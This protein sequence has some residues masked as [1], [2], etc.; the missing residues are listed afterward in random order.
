MPRF[1]VLAFVLGI[2]VIAVL[3]LGG[4]LVEHKIPRWLCRK[5]RSR[6]P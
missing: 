1:D 6:R 2:G 4:S 3:I 5:K